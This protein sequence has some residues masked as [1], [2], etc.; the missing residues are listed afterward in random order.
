MQLNSALG[1]SANYGDNINIEVN[2]KEISG[3]WNSGYS[4]DKHTISST[5]KGNNDYGHMQY[6]TVRSEVGGSTIPVKISLRLFPS[7][8]Y[9][10]PVIYI[11]W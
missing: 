4:L 8:S 6:D 5:P 7:F 3:V 2:I 11:F 9:C 10:H 1:F